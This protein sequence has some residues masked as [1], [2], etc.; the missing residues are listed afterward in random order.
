M[1]VSRSNRVDSSYYMQA[2]IDVVV[3]VKN[4]L[5]AATYWA[6]GGGRHAS[7]GVVDSGC[8]RRN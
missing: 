7:D 3:L 2:G 1:T 5:I 8:G 4:Q 6:S